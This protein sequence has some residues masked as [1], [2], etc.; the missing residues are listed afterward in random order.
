[1]E[2]ITP[3]SYQPL[4]GSDIRLVHLLSG[5]FE[6]TIRVGI[7][8]V[9]LQEWREPKPPITLQALRKA[10]PQE[11]QVDQTPE[12][13][14]VFYDAAN[15]CYS[16]VLPCPDFD[17]SIYEMPGDHGLWTRDAGFE[18]LSY[19]WGQQDDR[20]AIIVE[21]EDSVQ[22]MRIGKNLASAFRH[23]RYQDVPRTLWVDA[24]CINQNDEDEKSQ[25]IRRMGTI[26]AAASRVVAWLGPEE[27][28]SNIA[29]RALIEIAEQIFDTTDNDMGPSPDATWINWHHPHTVLP[30]SQLVW[31]SLYHLLNRKWFRRLWIVQEIALA[32]SQAVFQCGNDVIP[33]SMFRRAVCCLTI[34]SD[35]PY[36]NL[37]KVVRFVVGSTQATRG[38]MFPHIIRRYQDRE[39]SDPHDKIFGLLGIMPPR[40]SANL[41]P[42]YS[43]TVSHT[44]KTTF[45]SHIRHVGRWEL[46]GVDPIERSITTAPSWVP[47]FS[48]PLSNASSQGYQFSAGFSRLDYLHFEDDP[49]RLAITGLYCATVSLVSPRFS[50]DQTTTM[51]TLRS[52]VPPNATT[53][54]PTGDFFMDAL[55]ITI[56]FNEVRDRHPTWNMWPTLNEWREYGASHLWGSRHNCPT[57]PPG[58]SQKLVQSKIWEDR[59]LANCSGRVLMTT[60]EGYIGLGPDG[61]QPGD[62]VCVVLGCDRPLVLRRRSDG[63]FLFLGKAFV[64]GLHDAIALLGPLPSPWSVQILVYPPSYHRN[65]YRFF[66]AETKEVSMEDPRL[67]PSSLWERIA[68][69]D[70]EREL[71][72][73]DPEVCSF[74]RNKDTGETMDSDPRMLPDALRARGVDLQGFTLV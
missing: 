21:L 31:E 28:N 19:V 45:L 32:N 56:F 26:Y 14:F 6:D 70:L 38:L 9:P 55:S 68:E 5:A 59:V 3:Y 63:S 24:I 22:S 61:T 37:P 1:M 18:A 35:L 54:Y 69:E 50:N 2:Q 11:Y 44:Y 53:V 41:K 51:Q 73:D 15:H 29:I 20:E 30:Y 42:D 27:N 7:N 48:Q 62:I 39:C 52:Y 58:P 17:H 72:G 67:E 12:G 4:K 13:R 74:F 10:I 47:D 40:F 60:N 33:R 25:Q 16:W 57:V 49:G 46:F 34:K 23:L 64:Y 65:M 36:P 43:E 8:H 71:T 66:N